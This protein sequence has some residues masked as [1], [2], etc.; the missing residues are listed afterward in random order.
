MS[1]M[2]LNSNHHDPAAL[3]PPAEHGFSARWADPLV[4]IAVIIVVI[5]FLLTR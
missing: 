1:N 2:E 5:A 4:L 3:Q